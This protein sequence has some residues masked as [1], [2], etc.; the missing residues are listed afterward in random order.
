MATPK[1]QMNLNGLARKLV[2]DGLVSEP[3]A[4]KAQA[5]A[6]KKKIPLVT[7]LVESKLVASKDLANAAAHEF[8]LP[9]MDINA[10]EIDPDVTRLVDE[11]LVRQHHGLPLFKRGNRLFIG[12]CC[13][14]ESH[15]RQRYHTAG[16]RW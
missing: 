9:L 8:G 10:I 16:T 13:Y 6:T 5:E 7:Y 1:A 12:V 3:D 4:L 2:L 14:R 15:V 11:K